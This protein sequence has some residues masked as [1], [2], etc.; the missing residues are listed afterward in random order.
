MFILGTF[1]IFQMAFLPGALSLLAFKA[2]LRGAIR[3][4]VYSFGL[5][6]M[7][8]YL[9]ICCLTVLGVFDKITVYPLLVLE[10][11]LLAYFTY[12]RL[13]NT[14]QISF[15]NFP[16]AIIS[17][18]KASSYIG[19]GIILTATAVL[20]AFIYYIIK[21]TGG[22]FLFADEVGGYNKYAVEWAQNRFPDPAEMMGYPMAMTANF[23]LTYVILQNSEVHFFNRFVMAFFPLTTV[24][25][26][27]DLAWSKRSL[28][29]LLAAAFFGIV[30]RIHMPRFIGTAVMDLP[31]GCAAFIAF[32][33]MLDYSKSKKDLWIMLLPT[34]FA[35][36]A[37]VVKQAGLFFIPITVGWSLYRASADK[38]G[39]R[40]FKQ[41]VVRNGMIVLVGTASWYLWIQY[42]FYMG[43]AFS[44]ATFLMKSIHLNRNYMERILWSLKLFFDGGPI[45]PKNP[46]SISFCIVL[47]VCCLASGVRRETK[48]IFW[49]IVAPF[50]L[51]WALLFSYEIRTLGLA[52]PFICY[53]SALGFETLIQRFWP[54]LNLD[55]RSPLI[56]SKISISLRR[57]AIGLVSIIT[58]VVGLS[59][60]IFNP[61]Y[62]VARQRRLQMDILDKDL[63]RKLVDYH[64]EHGLKG[65][66]A[67]HYGILRYLPYVSQYFFQASG[68]V[69]A[70]YLKGL[71]EREDVYYILLRTHPIDERPY[72][73]QEASQLVLDNLKTGRYKLIFAHDIY[74]L[75]EIR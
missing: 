6:F 57:L 16:R 22:I 62:L 44:E 56:S 67:S 54:G 40:F 8:N 52:F 49:L 48:Y 5:S 20:F 23:A 17:E 32:Y 47:A 31:V 46:L 19:K 64:R 71:S 37:S 59:L 34:V 25:I 72:L 24:L 27:F 60:S 15:F 3:F 70:D 13:K 30:I 1:A 33:A 66:I 55:F 65:K 42:C 75:I 18:W 68:S 11:S 50:T 51:L 43:Y 39:S 41:L 45:Y 61:E 36:W 7:L 4:L 29:F 38:L 14:R 21:G 53:C 2:P 35:S 58:V 26:L 69:S 74:E 12:V 73:T 10:V 63:N 28:V 9:A